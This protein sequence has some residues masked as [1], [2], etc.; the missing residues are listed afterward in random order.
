MYPTAQ[1]T[2]RVLQNDCYP[3]GI[4]YSCACI[5]L[6][7][8]IVLSVTPV[9]YIIERVFSAEENHFL[10]GGGGM[11]HTAY[12]AQTYNKFK[13]KLQLVWT[14]H[15]H[16]LPIHCTVG[17]CFLHSIGQSS[18]THHLSQWDRTER[19]KQRNVAVTRWN[20][21]LNRLQ[22]VDFKTSQW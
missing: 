15:T 20:L 18:R 10:H 1:G 9:L 19:L 4:V 14:I 5:I 6:V 7:C 2:V 12:I 8:I 22:T 16:S 17:Y 21:P 13:F 11:L 3:L